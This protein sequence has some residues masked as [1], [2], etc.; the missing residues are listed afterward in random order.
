MCQYFPYSLE[1]IPVDA[2]LLLGG[3]EPVVLVALRQLPHQPLKVLVRVLLTCREKTRL[4]MAN[5]GK[6]SG[7]FV[8]V[9][10]LRDASSV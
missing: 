6:E 7:V 8:C 4:S 1:R 10:N 9:R 5:S 3:T 2:A